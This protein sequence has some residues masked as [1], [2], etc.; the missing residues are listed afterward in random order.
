MSEYVAESRNVLVTGGAGFIGSN[1]AYQLLL[2]KYRVVIFDNFSNASKDSVDFL[3][4]RFG[5]SVEV[6]VGDV[7]D[8]S[9]LERCFKG[10]PFDFVIHLAGLKSVGD[11]LRDPLAYYEVNVGGLLNLLGC[12]DAIGLKKFVFSSSATVYGEASIVPTPETS[13][14]G[15]IPNPYGMTKRVCEEILYDVCSSDSSWCVMSLRYFNPV[16]ALETGF[17]AE[18]PID[19]PTNLMPLIV[20]AAATQKKLMIFGD[21]YSTA[22]GTGIRDYIHV[23]DLALG[24]IAAAERLDELPG[25]QPFNLGSSKGISVRMLIDAFRHVN[26]VEVPSKVGPRRSGDVERSVAD[27]DRA[28]QL[29]NWR[30]FKSI[31]DMCRDSWAG[32]LKAS[33]KSEAITELGIPLPD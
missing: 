21:D 25:F 19:T 20:K 27:C 2:L 16:G 32:F 3:V 23:V 13:G 1:V 26:H 15:N 30:A 31:E 10:H 12:M 29:L 24:H 4:S 11:S 18:S 17:L 22:D 7:L 28:L 5:D 8:A 14:Y 9:A 6:V 33:V